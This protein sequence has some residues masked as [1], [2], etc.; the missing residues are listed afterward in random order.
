MNEDRIK[1]LVQFWLNSNDKPKALEL[2][3]PPTRPCKYESKDIND[4]NKIN[5][6]EISNKLYNGNGPSVNSNLND[7]EIM[8]ISSSDLVENSLQSQE[9]NIISPEETPKKSLE[10]QNIYERLKKVLGMPNLTEKSPLD[11]FHTNEAECL[12]DSSGTRVAHLV[13]ILRNLSFEEDNVATLANSHTCLRWG[14]SI[15]LLDNVYSFTCISIS[16]DMQ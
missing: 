1:N 7:S 12:L 2:L 9:C 3:I 8:E 14:L 4:N 6:E 16:M 15:H 11:L 13:H 10:S 5:S